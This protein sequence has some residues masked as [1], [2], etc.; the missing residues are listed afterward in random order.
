MSRIKISELADEFKIDRKDVLA[1]AQEFGVSAKLATKTLSESEEKQLRTYYQ[2]VPHSM[3]ETSKNQVLENV[4][5]KKLDPKEEV[6]EKKEEPSKAEQVEKKKSKFSI[7][8]HKKSEKKKGKLLTRLSNEKP[9]SKKQFTAKQG[10]ALVVGGVGILILSNMVLFGL[11]ASG[12]QPTQKIIH[13]QVSAS[14]KVS[15]NGL[16]LQAKNYLDGFV[17]TYF[18][19]PENEKDQEQAVKDINGYFV[20]QLP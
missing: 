10:G 18:T 6:S 19:F 1:K 17:Q 13:E 2:Q 16:D 5:Q 3:A 4:G 8:G 11:M 7:L 12:Y 14:Q 9:P 15:G 20:Q